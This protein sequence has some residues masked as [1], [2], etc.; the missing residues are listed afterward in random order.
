MA[1][2]GEPASLRVRAADDRWISFGD[3]RRVATYR[4][5]HPT[6]VLTPC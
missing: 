2:R 6:E 5:E 3:L 4:G 1:D